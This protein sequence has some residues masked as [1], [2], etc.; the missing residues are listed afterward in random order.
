MNNDLD[1]LAIGLAILLA[2]V[3]LASEAAELSLLEVEFK[4]AIG[5]NRSW[6]IPENEK[7]GGEVNINMRVDGK[8]FYKFTR[9]KTN[10]TRQFRYAA[11]VGELGY[12]VSPSLDLFLHHES[13]HALD[14][15]FGFKYPNEN[16]IGIR[17]RI[18]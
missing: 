16:S 14:Y 15:N 4:H 3:T 17:Y 5:T 10:F 12:K 2:F 6:N 9:I 13:Q 1:I 18:K 11:Y 7:K 8:K